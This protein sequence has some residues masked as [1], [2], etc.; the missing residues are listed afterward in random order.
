M[1]KQLKVSMDEAF[2]FGDEDETL[3]NGPH[4]YDFPNLTLQQQ[5]IIFRFIFKVSQGAILPGKNKPSYE[6]NDLSEAK[7]SKTYKELECWHYHCGPSY[8][9]VRNHRFTYELARN[10][11]GNTSDGAIHYRKMI[12]LNNEVSILI[13]GF[14]PHHQD[15]EFPRSDDPRK[16]HPLFS[17]C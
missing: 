5:E 17:L 6:N 15:P 9:Q 2:E 11:Y 7:H 16:P 12:E 4:F 13:I 14:A 3:L 1:G 8:R 10:L